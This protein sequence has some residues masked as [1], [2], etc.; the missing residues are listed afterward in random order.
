MAKITPEIKT[1]EKKA[2]RES[3][4]KLTEKEMELAR[5]VKY[6]LHSNVEQL[7]DSLNVVWSQVSS[8]CRQKADFSRFEWILWK[9]S[10]ICMLWHIASL[11]DN[12]L[13]LIY[14]RFLGLFWGNFKNS[15][16]NLTTLSLPKGSPKAL[17]LIFSTKKNENRAYSQKSENPRK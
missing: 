11:H 12:K 3:R 1:K 5:T 4:N 15:D 9:E 13:L 7:R 8:K 6:Y 10:N 16:D 17:S 2:M 14:R